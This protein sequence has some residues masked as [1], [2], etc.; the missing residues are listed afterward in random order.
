M[1]LCQENQ[2]WREKRG[3]RYVVCVFPAFVG[4]YNSQQ[5]SGV[6]VDAAAGVC[7]FER[8]G[9]VVWFRDL[10]VSGEGCEAGEDDDEEDYDFEYA[11]DVEEAHSPFWEEGVDETGECDAGERDVLLGGVRMV[12]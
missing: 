7:E 9:E 6:V 2:H 11:E 4:V 1:S 12:W 10:E 8:V 3:G 5:C